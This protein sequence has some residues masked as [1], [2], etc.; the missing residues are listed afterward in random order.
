MPGQSKA[1]RGVIASVSNFVKSVWDFGFLTMMLRAMSESQKVLAAFFIY[2]LKKQYGDAKSLLERENNK[3]EDGAKELGLLY[4]LP[5]SRSESRP[6]VIWTS[7]GTSERGFYF[8]KSWGTLVWAD[9]V[10]SQDGEA[11]VITELRKGG[12][13]VFRVDDPS[14]ISVHP[15]IVVAASH[16]VP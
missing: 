7:A 12:M 16:T 1:K 9:N 15:E 3:F 10:S 6:F 14:I 13:V 11:A 4:M 2:S 8:G 5:V